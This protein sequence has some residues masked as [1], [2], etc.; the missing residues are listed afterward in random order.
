MSLQIV[1]SGGFN[2]KFALFAEIY[3]LMITWEIMVSVVTSMV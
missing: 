2:S 3:P 1:I